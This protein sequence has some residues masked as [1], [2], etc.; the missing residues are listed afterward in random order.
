VTYPN[1][2]YLLSWITEREKIRVRKNSGEPKPWTKD[3]ILQQYRFCNVQRQHDAVTIWFRENWYPNWRERSF[4]ANMTLGR[5]INE[6][7]T[8]NFVGFWV[9]WAPAAIFHQLK[10]WRDK[11]GRVF[12]PAYI[13][14]T[15]GKKM[16]K[17]DYVVRVASDVY[18]IGPPRPDD[19][20]ASYY[21]KLITTDGLGAGFLAAQ[22]IADLKYTPLLVDRH[23][24][25]TW[26]V[27][28]PGSQRG[29]NRLMG[30]GA[31]SKKWSEEVFRGH[32]HALQEIVAQ[33]T[34][35][36]LHAQDM[37]NCLCEFDKYMRAREG[38]RP[39]QYYDGR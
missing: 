24:W 33:E 20:L 2:Y 8:M 14:T 11:G 27:P 32:V 37:Q 21:K 10:K 17:L 13:V 19:Y 30:L 22:I 34:T 36:P 18:N 39:K 6:P 31:T 1:L 29:L 3:P 35:I 7:A 9:D 12:N 38:G 28:G 15:C 23:D 26:C 16:D 4:V 5:L 25:S